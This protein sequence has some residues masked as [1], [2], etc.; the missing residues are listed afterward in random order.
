M[1]R[2]TGGEDRQ[3]VAMLPEC[4]DDYIAERN[5]VRGVQECARAHHWRLAQSVEQCGPQ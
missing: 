3:Q 5:P 1:K 4:L 2:F